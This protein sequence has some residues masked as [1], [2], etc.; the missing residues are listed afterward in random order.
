MTATK[1]KPATGSP[2]LSKVSARKPAAA[3]VLK[4]GLANREIWLAQATA[5]FRPAF[6]SVGAPLPPVRV[7]VGFGGSRGRNAQHVIGVCWSRDA[8]EDGRAQVYVSPKLADGARVLD[9][10]LHELVHAAAGHDAGHGPA[11]RR[12]AV[13]LGLA[14]KMTA[15]VAGDDLK[16][17]LARMLEKLGPYPHAKLRET[18]YLP[19]KKPGAP[20]IPKGPDGKP[21]PKGRKKQGTR[22]IKLSCP[23]CGYVVRTSRKWIEVG[24]PTCVCGT[25]FEQDA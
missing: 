2:S 12:V 18:T 25:E 15:T 1:K 20:P 4:S 23:S 5:M 21:D 10:L 6:E 17:V 7:S 24:L 13:A 9:V 22:M 11:F 8:A 19:P 16:P 14:G 3:R